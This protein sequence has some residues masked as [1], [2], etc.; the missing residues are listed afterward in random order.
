M[1]LWCH[2]CRGD[3]HGSGKERV[4]SDVAPL[5]QPFYTR[6]QRRANTSK[7]VPIPA[8][9]SVQRK[10]RRRIW[11]KNRAQI[12][13]SV[14]V[15]KVASDSRGRLVVDVRAFDPEFRRAVLFAVVDKLVELGSRDQI[16]MISDHDPSGL[17]YQIDLRRESRGIFEFTCDVRSDGAWVALLKR[18]SN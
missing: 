12:L 11:R 13:R 6:V 3:P 17:G 7:G 18:K 9:F 2:A 1:P 16:I 8:G 10:V 14:G 15:R 4:S 5:L